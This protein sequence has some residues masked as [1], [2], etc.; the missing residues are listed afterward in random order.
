MDYEIF[1]WNPIHVISLLWVFVISFQFE[2]LALRLTTV[3]IQVPR[4]LI[5]CKCYDDLFDRKS[6]RTLDFN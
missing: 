1:A 5:V 2:L 3:I 6:F 4:A